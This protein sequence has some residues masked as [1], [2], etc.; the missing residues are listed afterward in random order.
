MPFVARDDSGNVVALFREKAPEAQEY[1]PPNNEEVHAFIEAAEGNRAADAEFYRSDQSMIRVY[2]D[3]LDVLLEKKALLLTD[4]PPAA[5]RKLL[6]RK[7][8]RNEL[9]TIGEILSDES[10]GII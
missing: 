5:Q 10:D 3:L 9:T 7:R 2:E 6:D 4:L 8:L 1:L